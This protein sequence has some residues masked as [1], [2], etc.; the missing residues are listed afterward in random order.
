MKIDIPLDKET[1]TI[2]L[3]QARYNTKLIFKWS[4]AGLN[5]VLLFLDWLPNQG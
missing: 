2:I 1:K 5:S 4:K 3:P